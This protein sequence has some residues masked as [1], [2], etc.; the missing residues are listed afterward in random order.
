MQANKVWR[1]TCG[2]TRAGGQSRWGVLI[3]FLFRNELVLEQAE[4]GTR[5]VDIPSS[6]RVLRARWSRSLSMRWASIRAGRGWSHL[7][8]R[9]RENGSL[10]IKPQPHDGRNRARQFQRTAGEG[11]DSSGGRRRLGLRNRQRS[12]IEEKTWRWFIL[13][14]LGKRCRIV[15]P[16]VVHV[17]LRV[18]FRNSRLAKVAHGS[19][20]T[21]WCAHSLSRD[22]KILE[23]TCVS[24]ALSGS[25]PS[26]STGKHRMASVVA[27]GLEMGPSLRWRRDP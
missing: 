14:R 2:S 20:L 17:L 15:A 25:R 18:F 21:G 19:G 5:W 12:A 13:V 11:Y 10:V 8:F 6:G 3:S 4:A 27:A 1:N 16:P 26:S 23:E 22:S 7:S 24:T 9:G